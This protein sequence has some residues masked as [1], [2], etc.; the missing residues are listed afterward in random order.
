M[1]SLKR[2]SLLSVCVVSC[3]LTFFAGVGSTKEDEV[4][5]LKK[6][7]K[8][9]QQQMQ[10]LLQ[11]IEQ[12]EKK[13][14][15]SSLEDSGQEHS[16]NQVKQKTA[17]NPQGAQSNISFSDKV[18]SVSRVFNPAISVNGLFLGGWAS[19]VDASNELTGLNFK[20]GFN[21][22]EAEFRFTSDVDP[23][24]K[25][26]MIVAIDREGNVELEEGF[27]TSNQLPGDI[28]PRGLSLKIGKFFTDFGKHNLLHSHQFPFIDRPLVSEAI[29]GDEGL[30]EPAAGLNYLLPIP[31]FS[32][33][34]I[35]GMQGDN[36]NL[37]V[38]SGDE[39]P[40]GA[41]L[42]HWKN[43]FDLSDETT[44]EFGNSYV[45]GRNS[46]SGYS[47]AIGVDLTLKWIPLTRAQ[48]RALIWQNEYIYSSIDQ[49]DK[50]RQE[51]GGL[52]TSLQYRLSRL[53]WLQGR[54]DVLGIPN[55]GEGVDHKWT[56]LA[57][58]VPS[59]FSA[60]RLQYSRTQREFGEDIDQILFQLNYTIGS[61]P[62]H[63]Y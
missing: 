46:G 10:R 42:G 26:D 45:G 9:M 15:E 12:I 23:Y 30:N 37:F 62:A 27:V 1:I 49:D 24:F 44:L 8:E 56:V 55:S 41:Y 2:R 48:D 38:L 43:F 33:F 3:Y 36:S 63:K 59:E 53:W 47:Q 29:F 18:G 22:Q 13:T 25:A 61:H 39:S 34:T 58:L 31:W 11:R 21:F 20:N 19:S 54:Y 14:E 5:S 32:E 51:T 57:A 17:S 16:Q 7:L 6:Q 50:A 4:A 35:Q 28:M 40:Q 60:L 52:Y